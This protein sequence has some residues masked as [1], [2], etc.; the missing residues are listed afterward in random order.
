VTGLRRT[1]RRADRF[2]LALQ[3]RCFAWNPTLPALSPGP[4][5]VPVA[6]LTVGL[7]ASVLV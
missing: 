5:D 1:L 7:V 3:A 6:L 4:A 2:A